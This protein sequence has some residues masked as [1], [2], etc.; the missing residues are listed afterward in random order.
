MQF[1]DP[2]VCIEAIVLAGTELYDLGF[3][4]IVVSVQSIEQRYVYSVF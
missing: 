2:H 3:G 4:V 1:D